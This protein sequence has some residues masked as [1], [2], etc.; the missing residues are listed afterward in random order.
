M[1]STA[2]GNR[3]LTDAQVRRVLE[4]WRNRK[5]IYQVARE[6]GVSPGTI[7]RVIQGA[8]PYKRPPGTDPRRK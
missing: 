6:Y 1:F 3:L 4:W 8:G 7:S 2:G 5:T